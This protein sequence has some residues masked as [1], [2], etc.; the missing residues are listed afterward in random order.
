MHVLG[1]TLYLSLMAATNLRTFSR[2]FTGYSIESR[3]LT[4][5][6]RWFLRQ[7]PFAVKPVTVLPRKCAWF[8]L[9]S[10]SISLLS[11]NGSPS[12]KILWFLYNDK[13]EWVTNKQIIYGNYKA[14]KYRNLSFSGR[15]PSRTSLLCLPLLGGVVNSLDLFPSFRRPINIVNQASEKKRTREAYKQKYPPRSTGWA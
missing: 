15:A 12:N 2:I 7:P 1:A 4:N 6:C 9:N 3:P 8:C 14:L 10:Q 13:I 11:F 5:R